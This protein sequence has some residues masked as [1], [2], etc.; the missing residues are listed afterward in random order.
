VR[1]RLHAGRLAEKSRG[2]AADRVHCLLM[3]NFWVGNYTTGTET[4]NRTDRQVEVSF[5]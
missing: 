1:T 5:R 3:Y 2:T 4:L